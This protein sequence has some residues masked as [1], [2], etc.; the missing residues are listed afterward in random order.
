MK[1]EKLPYS[2]EQVQ[3]R[4][5][6]TRARINK[7]DDLISEIETILIQ[8][9]ILQNKQRQEVDEITSDEEELF[10]EY[11]NL[12]ENRTILQPQ[13]EKFEAYLSLRGFS[14]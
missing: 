12:K 9:G 10:K 13:L 1:N 7:I 5:V 6:I 4:I 11:E 2:N 8:A 14:T 3:E